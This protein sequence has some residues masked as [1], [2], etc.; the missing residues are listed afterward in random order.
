MLERLIRIARRSQYEPGP[1]SLLINPFHFARAGLYRNIK[2]LAGDVTGKVLDVGC[3]QKP[4]EDLF[5]ADRYIGLE[6]DTPGNRLRKRADSFYDG[7]AFPF[8]D[9]DFDSVVINQVL[10]HVF[11]PDDFLREVRRVLKPGGALL[12][13]VPFLWDEHEQPHDYARYSS[14]GVRSLLEKN[15]FEIREQRK[16]V[17]DARV[18][19]QMVN[20]Y[21][22]KKT[23]TPFP[24]VNVLITLILM[25]PVNIF[26]ELA[27][28][29]LP[30]N[31]DLYLDN[32]ILARKALN[33]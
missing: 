10:E 7:G 21:I 33:A 13:T 12:V 6:L 3:G 17:A 19:F 16:S 26:G 22:Y 27:A 25:M 1:L 32:V 20:A 15:G 24:A 23:A 31:D 8:P 18:L 2:A 14:F 4:Y 30:R 11:T 5:P 29:V 9:G 28:F